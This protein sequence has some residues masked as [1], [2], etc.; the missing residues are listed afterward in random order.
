MLLENFKLAIKSMVTS[1]MRT[2]LSL[3]G[4]VIGVGSVVAIMTLGES[5]KTAIN[6]EMELS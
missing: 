1:K 5:V 2:F 6:G 4:I 3:L